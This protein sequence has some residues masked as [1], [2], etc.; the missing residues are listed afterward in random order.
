M[1]EKRY[2]VIKGVPEQGRCKIVRRA[3]VDLYVRYDGYYYPDQGYWKLYSQPGTPE[4]YRVHGMIVNARDVKYVRRE[5]PSPVKKP[6][7]EKQKPWWTLPDP[8]GQIGL[9]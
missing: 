7:E 9:I 1:N 6:A 3:D 8:E 5:T 4:K 2:T